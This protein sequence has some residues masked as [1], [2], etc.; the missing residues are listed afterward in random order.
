M[1]VRLAD[2]SFQY[3]V[4]IAENMLFEVGKFTF[5][6]DFF[7]LE[8]EEDYKIKTSLEEPPTD[9]ELKPLPD[10]LECVFLEEPSF[11]PII[12]SSQLSKEKKNKLVSVL[13][14]HK[15]AFA[16]KTT[17]IPGEVVV[18]KKLRCEEVVV[19]VI[20]CREAKLCM[21]FVVDCSNAKIRNSTSSLMSEIR[22]ASTCVSLK[23]LM[24]DEGCFS[25]KNCVRKFLR[26]L[27]PKW[28]AKVTAIEE[29]KNLT[30][31]SL[32]ELIGN[33][34]VYEEVI[35]KDSET[36]KSKRE[37]SRS[38]ALKARKESSDD[39]SSTSDSEDE[40]YAMAVRDFKKFFKRRGRFV[41]QPH[42]ERKSFQRNKDDKNGKGERKCFKCGDP[43]HLIGECPKLSKYQN[44][45]AFVGGSW[46]DSD[47][48]EEEKTK[49]EKCL[50]AK[51]SN[52]VL[53]E[54][55]YFSD[56]QSSLDE[57]DLDSEYSRLCKIGLKVMAKNKILKQAKIKLENEA[58]ELKD[59]L[60]RLEKG[61]EVNEECKLCQDLK[62]ENEKL[63]KE[64]SRLN[65]FNDS[66]HSL[67]KIISSQKPSG[68]K[69][70][71]GF[72][73]TKGS[74]SE[75]KQVNFVRAQEVESK[76]K[77]IESNPNS[78]PKFILI[79]NTKIPIASDDEVKRFY[80]P[81]LKP[82]VGFTK[83]TM[84]S[85]TPPPRRKENSHPRSKTPQPRRDQ[86]DI[87]CH[88]I[89]KI[90]YNGQAVFTNE[91]ELAS[92]EYYRENPG[93][94][95]HRICYYQ[96]DIRTFLELESMGRLIKRRHVFGLGGH[97]DCLPACLAHI[98]YCVVA[99]E[100]Y[101]LAYFFVKRIECARATSTANLPYDMF[102]TR[103][104][105]HVM[106]TYPHLDNGIYDI[107]NRVM[108]HYCPKIKLDD[109]GSD[110]GR[111]SFRLLLSSHHKGTSSHQHD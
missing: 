9:I 91:W 63:R 76:E 102:L 14:K 110:R 67:K 25:S 19:V 60:S 28:R 38:I 95:L 32:D 58:L 72:N 27:H 81:S 50:M 89:L 59:K 29:S 84:R 64:I 10:N 8:M 42:E 86:G 66:S 88:Q 26:A 99:E 46:S 21:K 107:L 92:L 3:L 43:N 108:R 34:K 4:G 7:I 39:D 24:N 103:L 104:Y 49:D 82:G 97:R 51:A 16:W 15:E 41:R 22:Q 109:L 73:F 87:N 52:E 105:R 79:N 12:I 93:T 106:E 55:E 101:N 45:K 1:S 98:L 53:F 33:L 5:P 11:L 85:K 37:Q 69:S 70:G 54:T 31:L 48:D 44:Q 83:P 80:K 20:K 18:V 75:T 61:K 65:Q 74:P 30:T 78:K 2:K 71:L 94:V 111:T 62:F 96:S 36:V 23:A 47:E 100:Q 40:E 13:K 90:P 17:N 57:N 68:D 6:A 56:D 35:K 77:L